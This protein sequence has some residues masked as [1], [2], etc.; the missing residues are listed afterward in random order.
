MA[1]VGAILL[2]AHRIGDSLV[3]RADFVCHVILSLVATYLRPD[4]HNLFLG[5]PDGLVTLWTNIHAH[6][7]QP[8]NLEA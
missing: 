4:D 8:R 1:A 2:A 6:S 7:E 3:G 5:N